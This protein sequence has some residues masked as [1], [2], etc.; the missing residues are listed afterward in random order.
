MA[1]AH[2]NCFAYICFVPRV[3]YIGM[4]W[5]SS[6]CVSVHVAFSSGKIHSILMLWQALFFMFLLFFCDLGLCT[7]CVRLLQLCCSIAASYHLSLTFVPSGAFLGITVI[8]FLF[9]CRHI[10]HQSI[11]SLSSLYMGWL[12]NEWT[13]INM[14]RLYTFLVWLVTK[15]GVL[16]L[17]ILY[18]C[19]NQFVYVWS[20]Y[21]FL[22]TNLFDQILFRIFSSWGAYCVD[23]FCYLSA[24]LTLIQLTGARRW[25]LLGA[26]LR[27]W[28]SWAWGCGVVPGAASRRRA[29]CC[30]GVH[31]DF[32]SHDRKGGGWMDTQP[33][34][35]APFRYYRF[36]RL[37]RGYPTSSKIQ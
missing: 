29:G 20:Y 13:N 36:F 15:C 10:H 21:C 31:V 27:L 18:L 28:P 3:M 9:C 17:S 6:F 24:S 7:I 26:S 22:T 8:F 16:H 30:A 5:W 2:L 25:G 12:M 14:C 34:T 37:Q 11:S 19:S 23:L 32:K 4:L 1:R 35:D 33:L